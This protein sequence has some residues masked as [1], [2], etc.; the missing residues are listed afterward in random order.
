M[1]EFIRILAE[2]EGMSVLVSSH[3]L[4][5]IQFLCD[6]VAI[7]TKGKIIQSETVDNLL[8]NRNN[9]LACRTMRREKNFKSFT[10]ERDGDYL[11]TTF[12]DK[13]TRME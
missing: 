7:M 3:L 10:E 12:E 8:R 1:R 6:R 9:H 4:S 5:E 13:D 11:V 2:D